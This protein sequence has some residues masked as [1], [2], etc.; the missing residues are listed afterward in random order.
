MKAFIK[1]QDSDT[2]VIYLKG[3]VDSYSAKPF[4]ATCMNKLS[5]KK[6][7]FNLESLN[8]VGSDGLDSFMNTLQ[9]LKQKSNL[10]FCCVSSEFQQLFADSKIKNIPIY[11]DEES[12]THASDTSKNI[13]S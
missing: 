3:Q 6:I 4:Y 2:M 1:D 10:Q 9:Q 8:F 13:N 11:E 5:Q 12:A 7:I